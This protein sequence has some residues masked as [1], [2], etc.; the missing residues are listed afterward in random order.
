MVH[1]PTVV[2]PLDFS[3]FAEH[4]FRYAAA[5]A[6][7]GGAALHLLHV[8]ADD[9]AGPAKGDLL[10]VADRV[11]VDL[12]ALTVVQ[13]TAERPAH[14]IVAYADEVGA[15]LV[16]MSRHGRRG[17]RRFL[18]G[19]QTDEVL[20]T[21]PCPVLVVPNEADPEPVLHRLLVPVDLTDVSAGLV[22]QA[23]AFAARYGT[24]ARL[25]VLHVL[26]PLPYPTGWIGALAYEL[27]PELRAQATAEV[28]ALAAGGG[29]GA[30]PAEAHV[31]HGP[32]AAV[33]LREAAAYGSDLVVLTS[34]GPGVVD[35]A[36]LGSVTERIV[37]A[38]DRPVLVVPGRG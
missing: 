30:P 15:D 16:V 8:A 32:P 33:V 5:L 13:R 14:A 12:A 18:L 28:E 25:D 20:R 17:L 34:H 31:E 22:A 9:G 11:G 1:P 35:R 27:L 24:G 37:R 38:A 3:P 7:T 10:A 2:V 26:A 36:L 29:P 4:A 6:R 21:A 19:S 23:R